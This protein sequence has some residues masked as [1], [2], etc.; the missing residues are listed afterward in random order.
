MNSVGQSG[1][2]KS[3]R[4]ILLLAVGLTAFTSTMKELNQLREF[5]RDASNLVVS[6]SS[7]VAPAP[8]PEVV[9]PA[10]IREIVAEVPPVVAKV[11]ACESSHALRAAAPVEQLQ[12]GGAVAQAEVKIKDVGKTVVVERTTRRDP[13][14]A[15]L[16]HNRSADIEL[17]ELRKQARRVADL[18]VM[19]MAD[20]DREVE[21]AVPA[22][23][24]F[25]MPKVRTHR[26]VI[27]TPEELDIL[28]S[29][30]RSL[31]LRSAG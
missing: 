10:Q 4:A 2:K 29:L 18:K 6:W 27:V 11:E 8:V 22:G 5:T 17:M 12:L 24:E 26:Q 14:V 21:I 23:V 9:V 1:H 16:R 30:N 20:D 13:Q 28:K 25:K 3:Y 7:A 19:I 31:N 15:M